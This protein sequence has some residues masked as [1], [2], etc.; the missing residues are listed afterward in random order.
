MSVE[1]V[2]RPKVEVLEKVRGWLLEKS[3][4]SVCSFDLGT[5]CCGTVAKELVEV[6]VVLA[7][8]TFEVLV[9]LKER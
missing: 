5:L 9:E 7:A 8:Y 6:E 1:D 2:P 3:T 4:G